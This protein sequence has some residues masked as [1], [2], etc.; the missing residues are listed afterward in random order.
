MIA[1]CDVACLTVGSEVFS[2]A[3]SEGQTRDI[4][5]GF[6]SDSHLYTEDY[7]YLSDSDLE[8]ESSHSEGDEEPPETRHNSRQSPKD[9]PAADPRTPETVVPDPLPRHPSSVEI[10]EARTNDRSTSFT[11]GYSCI[12]VNFCRRSDGCLA[13][14]GKVAIIRD[15]GAVTCAQ[16]DFRQPIPAPYFLVSASRRCYISCTPTR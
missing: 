15:M 2:D 4:N 10:C 1:F 13:R 3:F 16:Y 8:D 9:G 6:P 5:E 14:M 7:D 11:V 12:L